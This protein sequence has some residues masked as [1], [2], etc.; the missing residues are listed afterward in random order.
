MLA[1][2]GYREAD[3]HFYDKKYFTL[4]EKTFYKVIDEF[5]RLTNENLSPNISDIQY[6]LNLTGLESYKADEQELFDIFL[7]N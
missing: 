7:G 4:E 5:P 3:A 6:K 2:V 1:C